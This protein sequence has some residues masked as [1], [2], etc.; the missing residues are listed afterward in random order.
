MLFIKLQK[1]GTLLVNSCVI[2]VDSEWKIR[3]RVSPTSD[4]LHVLVSRRA[5]VELVLQVQ[6][7]SWRRLMYW[8]LT[9]SNNLKKQSN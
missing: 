6:V 9:T 1:D 3:R 4:S 2:V 5:Q 8:I 7:V